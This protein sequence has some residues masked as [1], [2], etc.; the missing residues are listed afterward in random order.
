VDLGELQAQ[1]QLT[2]QPRYQAGETSFEVIAAGRLAA[3]AAQAYDRPRL[4]RPPFTIVI[5]PGSGN[6]VALVAGT[7]PWGAFDVHDLAG[8]SIGAIRGFAHGLAPARWEIYQPGAPLITG[9]FHSQVV[10]L[11]RTLSAGLSLPA[12]YL[13]PLHYR[14]IVEGQQAARIRRRAG[15][16]G[17]LSADIEV[18]WLDRR[19]VIAQVIAMSRFEDSSLRGDLRA[20]RGVARSIG[21]DPG[22]G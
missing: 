12:N 5:G 18:P 15:V 8:A 13:L 14:F 21:R 11:L 7:G 1:R 16:T 19:L 20:A 3:R 6:P 2:L 17:R 10:K 9:I 4:K 22:R